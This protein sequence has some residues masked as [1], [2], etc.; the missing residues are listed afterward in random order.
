MSER[1][2]G[3]GKLFADVELTNHKHMKVDVRYY[4]NSGENASASGLTGILSSTRSNDKIEVT[5]KGLNSFLDKQNEY[6]KS[7]S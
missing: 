1:V 3:E 6:L 2:F 4:R 7:I 5:E